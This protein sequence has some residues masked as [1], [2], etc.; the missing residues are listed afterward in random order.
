MLA[1]HQWRRRNLRRAKKL[2]AHTTAAT[3]IVQNKPKLASHDT[4]MN[5]PFPRKNSA[6]ASHLPDCQP[7]ENRLAIDS[8]ALETTG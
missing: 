2:W 8:G 7:P 6:A 4:A 5:L 1:L 3:T